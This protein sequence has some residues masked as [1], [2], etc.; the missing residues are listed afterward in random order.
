MNPS[1][2][3]LPRQVQ[4]VMQYNDNLRNLVAKINKVSCTA[5]SSKIDDLNQSTTSKIELPK[6]ILPSFSGDVNEW[7]S[8]KQLFSLSID[9][10]TALTDSQKL[11]YLQSA[12]T[13]DAE[14]LIRGFPVSD[15][16]YAHA[17]A[18]LVSRYDNK[19]ELAFSQCS[20]L[21]TLK[22]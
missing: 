6:F 11:Q 1:P 19:K 9:S 7:L 22:P 8:F 16:N 20:K 13:G 12:F 3:E 10:N 15:E 4:R 18:T 17:W 2:E 5:I 21:F 14:R